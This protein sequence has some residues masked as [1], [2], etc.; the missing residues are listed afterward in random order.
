MQYDI[1]ISY[2]RKGTSSATAAYLYELLLRKGYNVFFDRKEMRS[3]KF[4]EQ[5]LEHIAAAKDVIIL[6]E[7]E[8]LQ[9]WFAHK[10]DVPRLRPAMPGRDGSE[11]AIGMEKAEEAPY[12]SDWFCREII[13]ALNQKDK[14]VIP[15][16]LNG[17]EMP[18]AEDLPPEMQELA[19]HQAISLDI[20]E[21]E[22]T[23]QKY[24]IDKE[25]L[26]SKPRNLAVSRQY[27]NKGGVVGS[28]L[29]YTEAESCELFE[30]GERI[31]TLT[32]D[33]DEDHPFRLPVTF[34]GEHRFRI[35]NNDTCEELRIAREI[36][37]NHQRYIH[38]EWSADAPNL[39]A[40]S[41]AEIEAEADAD[42]LFRWGR[43]LFEGTAKNA[44]DIHRAVLCMERAVA[45]GHP[46][47][48]E[49]VKDHGRG[50]H[51]TKKA[52]SEDAFR[53]YSM[54]A[55]RG[56]VDA[57][58][59][60]GWMN[61]EGCGVAKNEAKA[62]EWY[63][64]AA[65]QDD[66][67]AQY[68]VGLMYANR[69]GVEQDYAKALEWYTKAA[70]QG[71]ADAQCN[72]GWM[73]D[74]GYGV[75][76][77]YAQAV[78]W[79]T[80]AAEQGNAQAQ[81]SLGWMYDIGH[82]VA[83]DDAKAAEWWTKA[84][85]QGHA[86]AQCNLGWMYDNGQG[87]AQDDAKAVEWYTKA[88]EQGH[89]RAQYNLG[90]MYDIGHGVAQDYAKAV[91]WYTKAAEQ[92]HAQAQCNLGLMYDNG[93]GVA[94]DYAK[95]V[96][97][98]T[99]AAEQGDARGQCNLGVMY[100]Y[101]HGVAQDYAKAVEWYTKAAE[102]GHAQAQCNL[103][104][105]YDNGQGVAQDDAKAV[106]WYTKAAEQGYSDA[107]FILGSKYE[108][109]QD[110]PQDYAKAAE[111][112]TKAAEQGYAVAYNSL[113]WTLHLLGRY[114]EALP[115]AEKAVEAQ[116]DDAGILDTLAIVHQGLGRLDEALAEFRRC[117]EL[118][119]SADADEADLAETRTKIAELEALIAQQ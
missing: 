63:T 116:P 69:Y 76:K 73:Y 88:A 106:A 62:F 108:Y 105:M 55:E 111:W 71:H 51:T 14:N 96:E 53:W 74:I 95:A 2:K 104:W 43:G 100:E 9:S 35:I 19:M 41:D 48:C 16:L 25:Y 118:Q 24:F 11:L 107:Q 80:K 57:Q 66:A 58:F 27:Q 113:A 37:T 40:L 99:K 117:L 52:N 97:W 68:I 110:V 70:E 26:K 8:S 89:A 20:S 31:I 21:I 103:G 38:V 91:E 54:S 86:D 59:N 7:D 6:L 85:E 42:T 92:G 84:A 3:G 46:A 81:C 101:G 67:E 1:F 98:Y 65:E 13:H 112:Y 114:D 115:W 15:L 28:F 33:H 75:D 32:D 23:Y 90:W 109:G 56:N 29:F 87:V 47:A 17:Y 102:Q 12:K 94:Q 83:Q 22:E 79:Y 119:E 61:Y 82:G 18:A 4:N 30:C 93:H 39:W 5:L 36:E 78:E 49:F 60:L 72:L 64:K 77:D 34:A 45:Q 10:D 44:P 50:V